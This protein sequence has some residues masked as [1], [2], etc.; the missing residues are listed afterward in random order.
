MSDK[1]KIGISIGDVNG[2]GLEII[3]K[4]LSDAR[5]YD[6]C[7]PIVYG[8][9]K[10]AS[11]H[12]RAI[13]ANEFNFNVIDHAENAQHKKPNMI[14]CWEEDV[15]ID[16]GKVTPEGGKYAFISLQRA[17]DDL[18]SGHID[19]LVTAP[20]NKDNIQNDDFKFPG[21]T[22]YLQHRD[23]KEDSLM[24]LVSDNLRV[25]VV[26]GHIPVSQIAQSITAEKIVNKLKLMSA[27]LRDDFWIRKP[28]IAVLGLNPHAGDNGLIGNEEKDIIIPAIE[29]ARANDVLAFGP[30]A[31]DG[32]FANGTYMQFDA[33]LAMYHDQGLIPFKQIAFE[34]GVNYTA[35]LSFV[36]TSPDHGTAYDIAGRNMASEVSFRE[37]LFTAIHV[38][39]HRRETAEL[40]ENPLLFSKLSR[41]RD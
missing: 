4:T 11:F 19:G 9:T 7:T 14:N 10:V 5:I 13:H 39:K 38:I 21:H 37:A 3:I 22:E 2:I 17:T 24:F 35:G 12:R 29:E 8:H 32:F 27:S 18:L 20:I 41:D 25:G 26:T 1:P 30:Y 31:A 15:R 33:V 16:M 28:K 40:N 23:S 6:Y 34:T 36:R